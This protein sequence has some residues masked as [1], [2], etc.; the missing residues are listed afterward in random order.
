[1]RGHCTDSHPSA[2]HLTLAGAITPLSIADSGMLNSALY[3]HIFW[4]SRLSLALSVARVFPTGTMAR[5]SLIAMAALFLG[6][7]VFVSVAGASLC[8][9]FPPLDISEKIAI[10]EYRNCQPGNLRYTIVGGLTAACASFI[11]VFNMERS[12]PHVVEFLSDII[13]TITPLVFLWHISLPPKE[14]RLVH[15]AISMTL[16][17][18]LSSVVT[19]AFW[20]AGP[21]IGKDFQVV[22]D[23]VRHQQ[24]RFILRSYSKL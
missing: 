9:A 13:G 21:D 20:F 24:V 12:Y 10:P 6:F 14:R 3:F 22:M 17:T 11:I 19:C 18:A 5:K 4:T 15:G 1:V 23:G 16:L 7:C 2:N 8:F